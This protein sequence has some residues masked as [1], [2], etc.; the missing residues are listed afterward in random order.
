MSHG[1]WPPA[2]AAAQA[3]GLD[4]N[5]TSLDDKIATQLKRKARPPSSKGVKE[6]HGTRYNAAKKARVAAH[7]PAKVASLDE[8]ASLDEEAELS[9]GASDDS[10]DAPLPGAQRKQ[11][12]ARHALCA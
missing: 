2:G 9:S 11:Q 6:V 7:T 5:H 4:A 8:S 12:H 3:R 10:A 1:C